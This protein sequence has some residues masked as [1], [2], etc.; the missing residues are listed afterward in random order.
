MVAGTGLM[1]CSFPRAALH[2]DDEAFVVPEHSI[3]VIA[4]HSRVVARTGRRRTFLGRK[5]SPAEM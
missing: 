4:P 1:I 3:P 5:P 2:E